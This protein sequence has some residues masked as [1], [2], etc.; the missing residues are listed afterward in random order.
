[1]CIQCSTTPHFPVHK[2]KTHKEINT[3]RSVSVRVSRVLH[4]S[5]HVTSQ[6]K[7]GHTKQSCAL[8]TDSKN[9]TNKLITHKLQQ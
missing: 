8:G 5:R 2:R 7:N 6:S 9:Q 1:M 4:R 3:L